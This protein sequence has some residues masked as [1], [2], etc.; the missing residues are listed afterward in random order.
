MGNTLG[1]VRP[2]WPEQNISMLWAC[3]GLP[4]PCSFSTDKL[5]KCE[6]ISLLA[7]NTSWLLLL[8]L[9]LSLL[10]ATDFVSL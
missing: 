5:V 3:A 1:S 6:G 8:L 2:G 10:Q 7:Q 4:S 9:S